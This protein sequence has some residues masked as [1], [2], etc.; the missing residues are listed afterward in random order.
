[1]KDFDF[2]PKAKNQKPRAK[3]QRLEVNANRSMLFGF[4]QLPIANC[5]LL[6]GFDFD[7]A[8]CQLL[9]ANCSRFG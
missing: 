8:D 1:M 2:E 4:G 5:Q 9:I 3:S 6:F 7:L